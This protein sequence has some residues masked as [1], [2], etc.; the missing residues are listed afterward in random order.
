M[1][2]KHFLSIAFKKA[3][4]WRFWVEVHAETPFFNNMLTLKSLN[5]GGMVISVM[6]FN[7]RIKKL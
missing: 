7:G 3:K 2:I 4:K 6:V 1:Y 5:C